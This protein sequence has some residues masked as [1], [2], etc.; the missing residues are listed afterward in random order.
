VFF[1][2]LLFQSGALTVT[3]SA[4]GSGRFG[5]AVS[6][7]QDAYWVGASSGPSVNKHNLSG[8]TA[9]NIPADERPGS[10]SITVDRKFVL[11]VG[12]STFDTPL[13]TID[14]QTDQIVD[15]GDYFASD[16]AVCDD[17]TIVTAYGGL[18]EAILATY[19]I[20][21]TGHLTELVDVRVGRNTRLACSPGSAFVVA[22]MVGGFEVRS[23]AVSSLTRVDSL[24]P[25]SR[26]LAVD[27][28]FNP[29]TGDV[30]LYQLDA[31]LSV[32]AF[33]VDTGMFGAQQASVN[34]GVA[35][36]AV[37]VDFMQFAFGKVFAY[38]DALLTYDASLNLISSEPI[39]DG[40]KAAVCVSEGA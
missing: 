37:G 14:V 31:L 1:S 28:A 12:S 22:Y 39:A 10:L 40:Q 3:H 17:G 36:E 5:C 7:R 34:V 35:P 32:Y 19:N 11:F 26:K 20:N 13:T 16:V 18:G 27:I 2:R 38:A 29:A 21:G 24:I 25:P 33:D 8:G 6:L 23:F 15:T 30:Y 4:A 9:L